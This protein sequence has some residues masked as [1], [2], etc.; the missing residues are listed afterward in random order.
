M[1]TRVQEWLADHGW[2]QYPLPRRR[3]G[4]TAPQSHTGVRL[5]FGALGLF[6]T[7]IFGVIVLVQAYIITLGVLIVAG[8]L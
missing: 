3:F 1:L 7:M 8:V 6:W 2:M 5:V 4:Q